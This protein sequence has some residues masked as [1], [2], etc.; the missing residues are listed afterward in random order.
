MSLADKLLKTE[1]VG[2]IATDTVYGIVARAGNKAAVAR[3]Y[4]I[5]KRDEKPGTL[6]AANIEQL[7]NLGLKH[8][9]LKAVEQYW[10]GAISV[11]IPSGDPNLA[12]LHRGKMSIAVRI[13]DDKNLS[14][15]LQKTGP[16]L[17]SSA[18]NPG[19]PPAKT[20]QEAKDYFGNK[21]DFYDD[22]GDLSDREPSTIIRII[23][24]AVEVIRQGAVKIDDDTISS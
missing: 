17:T 3:L 6:I 1:A 4:E 13:P 18:N 19:E 15:L 7:E 23:D 20:I 5:K 10:P 9:Y 11:I 24:D 2:I 22:G 16:L 14:E 8:R 21:P 12:Y